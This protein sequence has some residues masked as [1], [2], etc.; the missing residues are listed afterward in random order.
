MQCI[1]PVYVFISIH[2]YIQQTL[3][4][5]LALAKEH[6]DRVSR[7]EADMATFEQEVTPCGMH[8]K[9]PCIHVHMNTPSVHAFHRHIAMPLSACDKIPGWY[10]VNL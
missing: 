6:E 8:H 3:R 9:G 4:A 7:L 2:T 1:Q 5:E 10:H